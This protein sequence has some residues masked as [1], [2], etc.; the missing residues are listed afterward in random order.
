MRATRC[1]GVWVLLLALYP[2]GAVAQAQAPASLAP[3]PQGFDVRRD[4]IERGKVEP[5]R[6][7][8]P[9]SGGSGRGL[10]SFPHR[11]MVLGGAQVLA[12]LIFRFFRRVQADEEENPTQVDDALT[13][14]VQ[15][16]HG[17]ASG[18]CQANDPRILLIPGKVF[19]PGVLAGMVEKR[20]ALAD[21]VIALYSVI[22]VAV[23]PRAREGQVFRYCGTASRCGDDVF[24]RERLGRDGQRAAAVFA[25]SRRAALDRPAQP[26]GDALS[27]RQEG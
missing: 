11:R 12:F 5:V 26:A 4:G 27:Q 10:G 1:L 25:A 23:A 15:G 6:A 3:A 13:V 22:F 8:S 7:P 16:L 20:H 21:R 9:R 19:T 14:Q 24:H 2:L 18:R 17:R